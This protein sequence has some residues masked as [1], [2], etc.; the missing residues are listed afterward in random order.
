MEYCP[1]CGTKSFEKQV[2]EIDI[3]VG[4]QEHVFGGICSEC[5]PIPFQECCGMWGLTHANWCP[6]DAGVEV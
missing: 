5:G 4:I 3:G 1:M 2:D 6:G